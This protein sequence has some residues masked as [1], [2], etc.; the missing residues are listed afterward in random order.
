LDEIWWK[1]K[2][3]AA[4]E[5]TSSLAYLADQYYL[6]KPFAALKTRSHS[7]YKNECSKTPIDAFEGCDVSEIEPADINRYMKLRAKAL[8]GG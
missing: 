5:T 6:S 4:A 7:G 8:S 1:Y 2:K 3:F